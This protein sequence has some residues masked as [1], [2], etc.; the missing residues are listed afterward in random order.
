MSERE[1]VSSNDKFKFEGKVSRILRDK[2][3]NILE[4][5]HSENLI[6]NSG[7]NRL[8]RCVY[9]GTNVRL[10]GCIMGRDKNTPMTIQNNTGWLPTAPKPEDTLDTVIGDGTVMPRQQAFNKIEFLD[11]TGNVLGYKTDTEDTMPQGRWKDV[12][13]VR[14]YILYK[15]TDVNMIVNCVGMIMDTDSKTSEK[16]FSKHT[17]PWMYLRADRGYSLEI[18]WTMNII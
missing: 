10:I 12:F 3:G 11:M 1:A 15:S 5:H 16:L 13:S 9:D 6:V 7:K 18:I 17:F 8:V 2:D 14:Y 4:A